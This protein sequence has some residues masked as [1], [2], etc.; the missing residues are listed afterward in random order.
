MRSGRSAV[1][2]ARS[3]C[4]RLGCLGV[5]E[6][7]S[8]GF[9]PKHTKQQTTMKLQRQGTEHHYLYKTG[10]WARMRRRQLMQHPLC[11]RCKQHDLLTEA[12]HVDHVEPHR[13]VRELFF[14]SSNL[15][16]LCHSCHTFKTN[17]ELRGE[18]LDFRTD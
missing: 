2:P 1:A 9:C 4:K 10:V 14:K 15:Q 7:G 13:G 12:K 5:A 3:K 18:F 6:K 16:S 17:A 8:T 11:A